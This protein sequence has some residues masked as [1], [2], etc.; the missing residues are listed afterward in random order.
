M[1]GSVESQHLSKD[2]KG[3]T[4][5]LCFR[6]IMEAMMARVERTRV[7]M[8]KDKVKEVSRQGWILGWSILEAPVR[9]EM[10]CCCAV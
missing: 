1:C 8:V 4:C 5:P 9:M 6:N 2:S 3:E 10:F 7:T